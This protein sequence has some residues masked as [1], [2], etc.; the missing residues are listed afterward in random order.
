MRGFL[1]DM[2]V[3]GYSQPPGERAGKG[4]SASGSDQRTHWGQGTSWTRVPP[5]FLDPLHLSCR[6]TVSAS[7]RSSLGSLSFTKS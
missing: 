6:L 5:P 7:N 1:G 4:A 2:S 3:V